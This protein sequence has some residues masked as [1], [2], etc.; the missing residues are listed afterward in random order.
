M[1]VLLVDDHDLILKGLEGVVLNSYPSASVITASSGSSALG[2]ISSSHFDIM[3]F[4]VELPDMSGIELVPCVK[5]KSKD[6]KVII[7]TMHDEIWFIK[8]L[9]GVDV[10]GIILKSMDS[11]EIILAMKSVLSGEKYYCQYVENIIRAGKRSDA[12][13][14]DN[15]TPRELDVLKAISEGK[16]T[17]EIARSLFLSV[18]TVETHR[19]RMME[20]LKAK[21]VADLI[22]VAVSK[23]IIPLRKR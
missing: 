22:M 15:L 11:S 23:G 7:N 19:R 13:P 1:K 5:S 9:L 21:N 20:K 17:Q 4:D 10:D 3:I 16:N 12:G 8:S 2:Y 18:N 14:S 6:T